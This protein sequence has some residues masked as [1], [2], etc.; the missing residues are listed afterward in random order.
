MMDRI[1]SNVGSAPSYQTNFT[2]AAPSYTNCALATANCSVTD[3]AAYDVAT[4]KNDIA[5][6]LPEGKGQVL[7]DGTPAVVIVTLK[8]DVTH[9]VA[10]TKFGQDNPIPPKQISFRTVL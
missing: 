6:V 7:F 3:L 9:S 4:W 1:R 8:Y 2:T 10:A 5:R